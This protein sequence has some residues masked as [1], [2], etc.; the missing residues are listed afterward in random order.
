MVLFGS[1]DKKD[2]S[3]LEVTGFFELHVS[4]F[5]CLYFC[6]FSYWQKNVGKILDY[7]NKSLDQMCQ[8]DCKD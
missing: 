6:I 3:Q 4:F 7:P 8:A 5:W 1:K 2:I